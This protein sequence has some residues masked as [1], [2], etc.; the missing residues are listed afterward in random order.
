MPQHGFII[1]LNL[2][3]G[4]SACTI[5][6][7]GYYQSAPGVRRRK[8]RRLSDY[9]VSETPQRIHMSA[10]CN[11][12]EHPGCMKACPTNAYHK[13]PE[14]GIVLHDLEVCIGCKM[15]MLACPY[16]APS[17]DAETGKV[18]KCDMCYGR[19]KEGQ[20]P[21]C[22]V[23]CPMEAIEHVPDM[24]KIPHEGLE[25]ILDGYPPPTITG[26]NI[27]F[28]MPKVVNQVRR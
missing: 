3:I 15:C 8:I 10:S 9:L 2:C 28:K 20:E 18:D 27:M 12:C 5:A 16:E 21:F 23:A 14:T 24:T 22:V 11:H 1:D 4:C 17:Y 7:K 26:A 19:I 25:Y 13:D 6:C